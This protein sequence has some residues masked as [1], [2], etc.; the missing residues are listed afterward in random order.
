MYLEI[1]TPDKKIFEGEVNLVQLPGSKGSFTMLKNHAPIISTL[2]KGTITVKD[3]TGKE[4]LF[5]INGGVIENVSNK[6][7]VLVESV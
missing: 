4:F 2:E 3:V 7:I 1:I 5:N 6:V